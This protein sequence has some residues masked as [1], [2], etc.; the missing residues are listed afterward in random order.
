M[1]RA[2]TTIAQSSDTDSGWVRIE[3]DAIGG[4]RYFLTDPARGLGTLRVTFKRKPQVRPSI[5]Q[6]NLT[7]TYEYSDVPEEV[8]LDLVNSK[9]PG[10]YFAARVRN[11][12][13]T[14]RLTEE[15]LQSEQVDD[16]VRRLMRQ[17]PAIPEPS[18]E[19]IDEVVGGQDEVIAAGSGSTRTAQQEGTTY[20][21][22]QWSSTSDM[23]EQVNELVRTRLGRFL[24]Y[25]YYLW[26]LTVS[27]REMDGMR[28]ARIS[29]RSPGSWQP[30][31]AP[32]KRFKTMET[33]IRA[34]LVS[35]KRASSLNALTVETTSVMQYSS[36]GRIRIDEQDYFIRQA[37]MDEGDRA[38]VIERRPA[39]DESGLENRNTTT[40]R[41]DA[42]ILPGVAFTFL[43]DARN[44]IC[45]RQMLESFAEMDRDGETPMFGAA[46]MEESPGILPHSLGQGIL[47]VIQD[48]ANSHGVKGTVLTGDTYLSMGRES[49]DELFLSSSVRAVV[50]PDDIL[51]VGQTMGDSVLR[52][53]G[54]DSVFVPLYND[55]GWR[56]VARDI[57]VL[58]FRHDNANPDRRPSGRP[59]QTAP[60]SPPQPEQTPWDYGIEVPEFDDDF[61]I[62]GV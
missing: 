18:D 36:R 53:G 37:D 45:S 39:T 58:L 8:F 59:S 33:A 44:Y 7:T 22:G 35:L 34:L 55:Y 32:T 43:D 17:R 1:P 9:T 3:S 28:T 49:Q 61:D 25:R 23:A 31:T 20:P 54:N 27:D 42:E 51:L 50:L 10:S 4:A 16:A 60:A 15:E 30:D 47:H 12:F 57:G 24:P 41:R 5:R 26:T 2:R 38:Y 14:K 29:R 62:T 40:H 52:L 11:R 19:A 6:T 13:D 46:S 56:V 21:I 48:I